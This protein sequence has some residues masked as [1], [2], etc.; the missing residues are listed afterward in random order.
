MFGPSQLL[1]EVCLRRP[2]VCQDTNPAGKN[3]DVNHSAHEL[4]RAYV[5]VELWSSLGCDETAGFF[6]HGLVEREPVLGV[7]SNARTKQI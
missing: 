1:E 7:A 6:I 4:S 3:D 2:V 5:Q